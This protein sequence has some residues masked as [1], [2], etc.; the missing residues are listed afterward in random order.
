[1]SATFECGDH[2]SLVSY[3]YDEGDPAERTIVAA[4]LAVCAAC[5]AELAA[6]GATRAQLSSW[7][8]PGVELGFRIVSEAPRA[9]VIRP[10]R[11]WRPMPVWA[12]AAAAVALFGVGLTLGIAR[13]V[14]E[15]GTTANTTTAPAVR[16]VTT[17]D[18]EALEQRLLGE[19][20]QVRALTA[21]RGTEVTAPPGSSDVQVLARVRA[22]IEESEQR[23]RRE[24]ALRTAEV[25]RDVDAQRQFDWTRVQRALGQVEGTAGAELQRQRQEL[26]NLIR[27]SQQPR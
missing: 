21:V 2:A 27:V 23:Q 10:A 20:S 3:L 18:L 12:Q 5:A 6:L 15:Q 19:L 22:L 7:T 13:G 25:V 4:H 9:Q 1:M 8:P 16:A 26:N 17:G 14:G 24:L 11:W